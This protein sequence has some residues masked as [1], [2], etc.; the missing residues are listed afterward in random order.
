MS[1]VETVTV[2]ILDKEY[3]VSCKRDEVNAL[4]ES[5]QYLDARMR[6][7][8]ASSSVLGLDRIAVMAALNIANDYLLESKKTESVVASQADEIRS[9]NGKLDRA[10]DKLRA[11][12]S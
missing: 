11:G 2:N 1:D 8:K 6:E 4:K 5:A 7:V 12:V 10:L 9:L 3:Q